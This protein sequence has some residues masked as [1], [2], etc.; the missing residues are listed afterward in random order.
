MTPPDQMA[1][2]LA[3]ACPAQPS[4]MLDEPALAR[5]RERWPL[6]GGGEG[7]ADYAA[8]RRAMVAPREEQNR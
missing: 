6:G 5:L 1:A 4:T 2:W 7:P 8:L 3:W